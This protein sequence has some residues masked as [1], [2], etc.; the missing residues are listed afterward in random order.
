MK[1][2][3]FNYKEFKELISSGDIYGLKYLYDNEL[4]FYNIDNDRDYYIYK[5]FKATYYLNQCVEDT[6]TIKFDNNFECSIYYNTRNKL[7][8][9][10]GFNIEELYN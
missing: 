5:L 1:N 6:E 8:E 10:L 3:D 9:E 2:K 4:H 7:L